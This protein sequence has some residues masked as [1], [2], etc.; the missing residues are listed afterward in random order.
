LTNSSIDLQQSRSR[1][2]LIAKIGT[3]KSSASTLR[4]QH[5]VTR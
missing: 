4:L 5:Y 3:D 2:K 1:L